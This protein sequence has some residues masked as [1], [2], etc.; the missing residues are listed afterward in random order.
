MQFS[1]TKLPTHTKSL[2]SHEGS[3]PTPTM[4]VTM[5]MLWPMM[6]AQSTLVPFHGHEFAI[7]VRSLSMYFTRKKL[8]T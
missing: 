5:T 4:S 6:D 1:H 3:N 2:I 8:C 7:S